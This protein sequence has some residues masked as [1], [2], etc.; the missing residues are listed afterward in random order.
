MLLLKQIQTI[1]QNEKNTI[2][3][4]YYICGIY[5][6]VFMQSLHGVHQMINM[7]VYIGFTT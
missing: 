5:S 3:K 7:K 1:N 6:L 4:S 2:H